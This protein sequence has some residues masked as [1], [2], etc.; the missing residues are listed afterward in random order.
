[1]FL[2][3]AFIT[4]IMYLRFVSIFTI[5]L[6]LYLFL[7]LYVIGFS[8]SSPIIWGGGG[9]CCVVGVEYLGSRTTCPYQNF[10]NRLT[11]TYWSI[12]LHTSQPCGT[13]WE[14]PF[15]Y[16]QNMANFEDFYDFLALQNMLL[17]SKNQSIANK[18]SSSQPCSLIFGSI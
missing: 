4:G 5:V 12:M 11:R 1:M 7:V 17:V 16:D 18:A 13:Q 14:Y 9:Y 15:S 2:F 8:H 3:Q 6:L 10:I